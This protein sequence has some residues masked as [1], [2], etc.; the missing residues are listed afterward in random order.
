[1][2]LKEKIEEYIRELDNLSINEIEDEIENT[3][4][5]KEYD[6]FTVGAEWAFKAVLN[7]MKQL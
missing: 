4:S 1:M 2:D 5:A 7:T 3:A 6:A